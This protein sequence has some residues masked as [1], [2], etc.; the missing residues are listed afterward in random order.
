M[1]VTPNP[2]AETIRSLS[3]HDRDELADLLAGANRQALLSYLTAPLNADSP[4]TP[5]RLVARFEL[6]E[7]LRNGNFDGLEDLDL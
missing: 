2:L 3:S 7:R 5:D 1:R 6:V 4:S